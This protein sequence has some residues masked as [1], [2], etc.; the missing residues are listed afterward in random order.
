MSTDYTSL[1]I[2]ALE[3]H[4]SASPRD[5]VGWAGLG[6]KLRAAGHVEEAIGAHV[7]ALEIA[8]NHAGALTSLGNALK[9]CGRVEEAVAAQRRAAAAIPDNITILSNLGI[10]YRE[11]KRLGESVAVFDRAIALAPDQ[12]ALRWDRAQALLH[13]GQ[14]ERAW[15]DYEARL[16]MPGAPGKPPPPPEWQGE[17]LEGK[18]IL[19]VSEQGFGDSILAARYIP[20][21]KAAGARVVVACRP[22]LGRLF[23]TLAAIDEIAVV[24]RDPLPSFDVSLAM[25]S[26]L[27]RFA[28]TPET[29]PPPPPFAIPPG[30]VARWREHLRLGAESDKAGRPLRVGIIWSGSVTFSA[31]RHRALGLEAFLRFLQVGGIRLYSLQKGA[32]ETELARLGARSLIRPL[33]PAIGDFLDTAALLQHL[34]L[35]L[36]TDSGTAHLAA[37][38]GKPVWNLLQFLPYWVYGPTAETT[39]WYRS[40]RLFRQPRPGDWETVLSEAMTTLARLR[41]EAREVARAGG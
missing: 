1:S 7:R 4:L 14:Y 15:P 8:P 34:D 36:M 9:D 20:G 24:G 5:A 33:G 27:V 25:M 13:L 19:L 40:M 39:P 6:A 18:T 10:A 16:T 26:L 11:A 22:E 23:R 35:V 28:T 2:E 21:L 3:A 38:L 41:D 32:P 29:I 37:S 31:N 12:P 17:R 30:E